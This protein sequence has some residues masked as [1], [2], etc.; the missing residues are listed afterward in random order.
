MPEIINTLKKCFKNV[1]FE[2]GKDINEIIDFFKTESVSEWIVVTPGSKVKEL[3]EKLE[4]FDCIKS[5]FIYCFDVKVNELWAKNI[6]KIGCITSSLEILCKKFIEINEDYIIPKFNYKFS[7]NSDINLNL[8]DEVNKEILNI[9]SSNLKILFENFNLKYNKYNNLC[10]KI[11]NYLN[12]NEVEEYLKEAMEGGNSIFNFISNSL[13]EMNNIGGINLGGINLG[14]LNMNNILMESNIKNAKNIVLLSLYFNNYPYLLN[15]L[16]FQEVIE[17]FKT[18]DNIDINNQMK[19]FDN[20]DYLCGMIKEN[21]CI[22]EEEEALREIQITSIQNT[23]YSIKVQ[24]LD[25]N[26]FINHY[27]IINFYRDVDFCLKILAINFVSNITS[28]NHNFS[29]EMSL[30]LMAIENRYAMY[31]LY[32]TKFDLENKFTEEEQKKIYETL[33]IK[34]FI[35]IG[36]DHFHSKIK[37]IE[38]NIKANSFN[39]LNLE[40]LP[41][42]LDEKKPKKGKNLS[43]FFYFLIIR[44]EDLYLNIEKIHEL[45]FKYGLTILIFLYAENE[46]IVYYK[47]KINLIFPIIFVYSPKDIINYLSQKFNIEHPSDKKTRED[48]GD[49]SK[50]NF[51]KITFEQGEE[52]KYHGGCFELAETFDVNIIK[53]SSVFRVLD[54]IDFLFDFTKY[55]YIIYKEHNALD[56]FYGQNC[57]Y[58]GWNMYPDLVSSNICFVKRFIYMYC[59]EEKEKEK[60]LYRIINDDLRS[61]DSYKIFRYINLLALINILIESRL[62]KSFAGKVYRATKLDENL[63]LKLVP[64]AKMVNTT[65][66]STSKEFE[67]AEKFMMKHKWRNSYIICKNSKNNIDIDLEKLNPYD[68]KEVLFLP[69]TEFIVENISSEIKYGRK[70]FTIEMTEIGDRNFVNYENMHVE[71]IKDLGTKEN[72]DSFLKNNGEALGKI[73]FK[74]MKFN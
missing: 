46:K 34:D 33:T 27:Q 14:D 19:L 5:F 6:K 35:I 3:I 32:I 9:N 61:R 22:I 51:P 73:V 66:W 63:I 67:I 24:N 50:M 65:F 28:K 12:S 37:N 47:R 55:I 64:G 16:S 2:K 49:I 57:L 45:C 38:K 30:C 23:A 25:I 20:I 74:N 72:I 15:Y 68:E 21:K 71:D 70:I 11:I 54:F 41:E 26:N 4:K 48:L 59:R 10:I 52:D 31:M 62:L 56:L 17:L 53:K 7:A 13:Q 1:Q 40:K 44:L 43:T 29:D 36:N 58:L 69:F 39:Y 60:S 18:S 8:N 42:F